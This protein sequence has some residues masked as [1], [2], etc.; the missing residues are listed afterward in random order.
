MNRSIQ[1][2]CIILGSVVVT[3]AVLAAAVAW[4]PHQC[5]LVFPKIIGCAI[6]SYE[7]IAGGMIAAAT[8]LFA[9]WL[10]WSGVQVQIA[11]EEKRAAAD[12]IEV[13]RVLQDDLNIFAEALG[14]IFK[15]L[16]RIK[17]DADWETI[18]AQLSGVTLG[19]ERITSDTW[20]ST[21]RKMVT[22]LGWERRR[23]YEE[24]F[25]GL[26]QLQKFRDESAFRYPHQHIN[27]A[28]QVV[29]DLSW[30]FELLRPDTE[31]YFKGRFRR[32]GKA[33][34]LGHAVEVQ[35]GVADRTRASFDPSD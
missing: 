26:E 21:S 34:T 18:Q 20:L 5:G 9:G 8:A 19:I 27:E 24:L 11:A 32:A 33:W 12:R 7:S 14:A 29:R 25:D 2:L 23:H 28:L 15:V 16:E 17:P 3:A 4:G 35:A 10:A 30:R 31:Q 1:G 13:E 6:G 22:L